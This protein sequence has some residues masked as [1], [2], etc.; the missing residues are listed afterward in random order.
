ML[1]MM[2]MF[3]LGL[4]VSAILST[5][6]TRVEDDKQLLASVQHG[7]TVQEVL[8]G[9][10][11]DE[12]FDWFLV[13]LPFAVLS[14][15]L[16]WLI[17]WWSLRPLDRAS[18]EAAAIG[19]ANPSGRVSAAGL[20]CEIQ[21]LVDAVN[22]ALARLDQA[23]AAQRRFTADAA[24]EL[25][26]PL[27]VLNLR[28]QR[29][30]LDAT[31]DWQAVE[32]DLAQMNRLVDQLMELARKDRPVA[33]DEADRTWPVNLPRVVREAAAAVL[34]LAEEKGRPLEI[35]APDVAFVRGQP[36]ELRDAVRNLLDNALTHGGGAVR[37][38]VRQEAA[39]AAGRWVLVEVTDQGPG[40]ADELKEAVFDRFRKAKPTSP[41][42]GLGLAIV[43]HT[44]RAH[45]GEV[46]VRPGPGCT[47][48][49]ALPG[50]G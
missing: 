39:D 3:A 44:V 1:A 18:R 27:A 38:R 42:A 43:R 30:R 7:Q 37:V 15:A 10:F 4:A 36:G 28:L 46:R 8:L 14:S 11:L 50:S 40:V 34:P 19:P 22:G 49:I 23:Y 25:R 29:A 48:E 24:H 47:V 20:P 17:G 9:I 13:F 45:G 35:E 31:I 26:T 12:A 21:P 32:Q 2:I 5:Q 33:P 41:G 16:I 6:E